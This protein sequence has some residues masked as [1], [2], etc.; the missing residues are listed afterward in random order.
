MEGEEEED[1]S[2]LETYADH[3]PVANIGKRKAI[4]TS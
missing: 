2:L 3:I 4:V 1:L